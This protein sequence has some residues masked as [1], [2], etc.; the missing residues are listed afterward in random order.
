MEWGGGTKPQLCPSC[1]PN[2]GTGLG[3]PERGLNL[4]PKV[5]HWEFLRENVVPSLDAALRDPHLLSWDF[6]W[7]R[8]APTL[9]ARL[10]FEH[11]H[12]F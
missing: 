8:R 2:V 1:A 12:C 11:G 4:L 9:P 6:S 10:W 7:S 3:I 5:G